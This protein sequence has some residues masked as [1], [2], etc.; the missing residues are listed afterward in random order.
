MQESSNNST[1]I[2]LQQQGL[3]IQSGQAGLQPQTSTSAAT[4]SQSS[5]Q[6]QQDVLGPEN[7]RSFDSLTVQGAP[8]SRQPVVT[9]GKRSTELFIIIFVVLLFVAV[10]I[11]KRY[12]RTLQKLLPVVAAED[13]AIIPVVAEPV[14]QEK[15]IVTKPHKKKL[16]KSNVVKKPK[17]KSKKKKK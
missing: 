15:P 13:T 2:T 17:P 14:Q 6:P 16:A 8:V 1:G 4:Q 11:F 7:Y 9:V 12:K 3:G 5:G 10:F